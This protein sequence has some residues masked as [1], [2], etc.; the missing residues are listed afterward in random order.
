MILLHSVNITHNIHTLDVKAHDAGK[1]FMASAFHANADMLHI[2]TKSIPVE[3]A[4]SMTIVERYHSPLRRSFNIIHQEAPDLDKH[5]AFQMAFKAVNDSVGPNGLVPTLLVFGALP[6]LGLPTD[7]PTPSTYQRAIA[8]RKATTAM[9]QNVAS[10]QVCDAMNARNG[11]VVTDIHKTPI[12]AHV[13]VYR[14]YKDKWEGPNSLLDVSGED[15]TVL[16]PS[17]P[18]KFRSTVVKPFL[19]AP[20]AQEQNPTPRDTL[21][22]DTLANSTLVHVTHSHNDQI[23]ALDAALVFTHHALQKSSDNT[24]FAQSRTV[25]FKGLVERGLFTLVPASDTEG[26]GIYGAR[27]CDQVKNEGKPTAYEKISSRH[28]SIQRQESRPPDPRTHLASFLSAP[29]ARP[30]FHGLRPAVLHPT[31]FSGLRTIRDLNPTRHLRATNPNSQPPPGTLLRV[32][33]PLYGIPEAGIHWFRTYHENHRDTLHLTAS[34]HEPCFLYTPRGI[35]GDHQSPEVARVFTCLQIDDTE[36][37]GN[38]AYIKLEASSSTLF[39]GKRL[40]MLED[41][42]TVTFNGAEISL[43]DDICTITQPNHLQKLESITEDTVEKSE[44]VAQRARGA[45]IAAVSRPDLTFA[46]AYCSQLINRDTKA[47]KSLN[48]A[49]FRAKQK[50]N[51]GLTFVKI[52][53]LTARLAVFADASFTRN[54]DLTSQLGFVM[55]ITDDDRNSNIIHH[56][57]VK[58][59]RVT[60]SMLGAELFAVVHAFDYGSTLRLTLNKMFGRTISLVLYTD[61]KSLYDSLVGMT[62]ITEKRLLID[63]C[64]LRQSYELR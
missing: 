64:M 34:L 39:D 23:E 5:A 32:D 35:F 28:A 11:L 54:P 47:A 19:T 1:N 3:F 37:A 45:Y 10:R 22:M 60:R 15:V 31:Y 36:T 24:R 26:H 43:R 4:N 20:N 49:I 27:F 33:R 42:G 38:P 41:G 21:S 53:I 14:P 17:G 44:F 25:E 12:G 29:A 7:K 62:A 59:E 48:K 50:V 51:F 58:S 40:Q 57:S 61:S 46:F 6:R 55:A 9:S 13:L 30:L 63:L 2:R 18:T 52:D 16:L 56:T 8:P